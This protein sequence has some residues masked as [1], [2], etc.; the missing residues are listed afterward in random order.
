MLYMGISSTPCILYYEQLVDALS[1]ERIPQPLWELARE[2][3]YELPA[4]KR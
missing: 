4:G 3:M 1:E 2:W